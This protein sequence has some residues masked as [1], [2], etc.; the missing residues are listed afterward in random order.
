MNKTILLVVGIAILTLAVGTTTSVSNMLIPPAHAKK[1]GGS[2]A[3]PLV[4]IQTGNKAL[5]K[6]IQ[7]FYSCIKKTG[8]TGGSKPEPSRA[9]V[10]NCYTKTFNTATTTNTV[11]GV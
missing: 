3:V 11:G 4:P 5:D 9:E 10:I 2:G 1:T 7:S 8:H 6:S